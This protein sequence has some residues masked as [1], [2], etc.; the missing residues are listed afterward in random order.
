MGYCCVLDIV[1]QGKHGRLEPIESLEMTEEL[2]Q[3][4]DE[5]RYVL[6]NKMRDTR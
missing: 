3:D 2:R 1:L 4:E 5:I 6:R